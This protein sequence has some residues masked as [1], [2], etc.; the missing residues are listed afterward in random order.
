MRARGRGAKGT[1]PFKARLDEGV[2]AKARQLMRVCQ[3][4][5]LLF[6]GNNRSSSR[7]VHT[8]RLTYKH[9]K[10]TNYINND[11]LM[12]FNGYFIAYL[13]SLEMSMAVSQASVLAGSTL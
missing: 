10:T 2:A 11:Y 7:Q 6:P 12:I 9:S 8:A 1:R 13:C 3:D 5:P 4:A